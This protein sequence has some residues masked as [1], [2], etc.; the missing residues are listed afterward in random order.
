MHQFWV[1]PILFLVVMHWYEILPIIWLA[2]V[3]I[4]II[5]NTDNQS[6]VY[7]YQNSTFIWQNCHFKNTILVLG[8]K[9]NVNKV[10]KINYPI[11]RP[12]ITDNWYCKNVADKADFRLLTDNRCITNF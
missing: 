3:E 6:D 11:N 4:H 9:N 12:T 7:I 8:Y 2:D 10:C 1:H 5:A